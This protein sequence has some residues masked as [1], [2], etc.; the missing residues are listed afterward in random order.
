MGEERG[1]HSPSHHPSFL[2]RNGRKITDLAITVLLSA[3]LALTALSVENIE[4][5]LSV[6]EAMTRELINRVARLEGI[7]Q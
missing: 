5:R 6:L 3:L 4:S 7:I 1:T 2:E